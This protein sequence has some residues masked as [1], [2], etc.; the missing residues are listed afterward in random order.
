M[1][2]GHGGR[3]GVHVPPFAVLERLI[4]HRRNEGGQLDLGGYG[5]VVAFR[6]TSKMA[7]S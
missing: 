1:T 2:V 5:Q 4:E 7:P 3:P 6:R